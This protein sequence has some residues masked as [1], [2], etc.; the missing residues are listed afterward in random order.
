MKRSTLMRIALVVTALFMFS[1]AF[2]QV[3]DSDYSEYDAN[4]TTPTNIDYVT[5]KTSGSTTMGYYAE[6]DAI[7][8]PNYNAGG[9]WAL[10]AGFTWNWTVPT[11][12][13]TPAT[14][15]YPVASKPANYVEITYTATGNYV[16]NVEEVAPAAFG[17]CSGS[18]TV[19]NVTVIDPPTAA[20][21]G[22]QANNSW[23]VTTAGHEY[24]ICGDANA[25]DLTITI[26]ETGV[27]SALASY[28]YS[29]QKRVVNIDASGT[30][31]ATSEVITANFVDHPIATK[32]QT[33]TADG[34]TETVSTGNMPV[35]SNKRTKYEFTLK[36]PTDA[37]VAAAEGIVSAISHKSDYLSIAAGGD[38]STYPF[39]GTVTV[40]YI[41]N[42]APVTGPIYHIANT[43][44]Y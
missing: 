11:D 20:I 12:P 29:V 14:V 27:P 31:D 17:G 18:T 26:T 36:K 15:T 39:T 5:L 33:S 2:A 4:K 38:V 35:V 1:G 43:Y 24:Y 40:V 23:G 32:Y 10:T 6:P 16:V 44:A 21:S 42:P 13:G 41:V 28:A 22:G 25:E 8:H 34:G 9:S 37:A 3:A 30:E 19:M 7:Y